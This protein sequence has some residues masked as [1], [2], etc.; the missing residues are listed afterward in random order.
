MPTRP[1]DVPARSITGNVRP[2]R[3]TS[4]LMVENPGWVPGPIATIALA[5]AV[6][7]IPVALH[8]TGTAAGIAACVVLALLVATFAAPAV[9]VALISSYLFQNLFVSLV[10]P[11]ISDM[12]QF[13][14]IRAYNFISTAVIWIVVAW[15][16][17]TARASFDRRFRAFMDITTVALISIGVY[18]VLGLAA[19]PSGALIYL[20][21]IVAPF[22][23]LQIFAVVA[24]RHRVSTVS[25]L[26][27]IASFTLLYGYFEF[28]A[29]D[30]LMYLVNGDTYLYWRTRDEQ[31][32]WLMELHEMGRVMRS[33]LDALAIDFLNTPLLRDLGLSTYR[34]L[35]PNFHF[36]SFAYA[37]AFFSVVL[38][39]LGRWWYVLLALPLL[40]VIGSKGALIFTVLVTLALAALP[41]LRANAA[42]WSYLAVLASYAVAGIITG[43]RMQDY[44]VIGF[45][46]G[47]L[48]LMSNPIGRGIG[49]GGNLAVDSA[50][51]DW[52]RSQQLGHVDPVVESAVG[53]LF[54]QMG[55]FAIIPLAILVWLTV[56]LWGLYL[57]SHDRLFAAG[58][59]AVMA[60]TVNGIF[61][62]EAL[63]APLAIGIV[64][65]FA[66]LLLGRAIRTMP[67][68]GPAARQVATPV[69]LQAG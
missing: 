51:I 18:F 5:A 41:Y 23:L 69:R 31:S 4:A 37:L 57:R 26:V 7:G 53:V 11:A 27:A 2:R 65:A 44:H 43:I 64:V 68:A 60:V 61:Q 38:A 16:F 45:V 20:R 62:E 52:A 50:T 14:S 56:K 63:F 22:L 32:K 10:S 40:L 12:D 28:I 8:L 9:P 15:T 39:A 6:T 3:R 19:N 59:Y 35:G 36:I 13:N 48:G 47:V 33:Y 25:A 54:Y 21:N 42:L 24:Y 17:W 34:I 1:L 67:D 30:S 55:V 49:V 29:H 58:A 46:G 66:G